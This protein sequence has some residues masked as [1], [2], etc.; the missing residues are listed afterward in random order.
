MI[1]MCCALLDMLVLRKFNSRQC[2][3]AIEFRYRTDKAEKK[4]AEK[5]LETA[6]AEAGLFFFSCRNDTSNMQLV[7]V[8]RSQH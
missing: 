4:K 7:P 1:Y 6:K 5:S 8:G 3:G 2:Q